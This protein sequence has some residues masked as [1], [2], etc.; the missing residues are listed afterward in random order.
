MVSK[1]SDEKWKFIACYSNN[2]QYR[3]HVKILIIKA[4]PILSQISHSKGLSPIGAFVYNCEKDIYK[5]SLRTHLKDQVDVGYICS[6][7]GG[8]GHK[9]AAAFACDSIFF[10]NI[11]ESNLEL[12]TILQY[13]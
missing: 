7:F 10:N 8:G 13:Y 3:N 12:R 4:C 9:S 11:I 2:K 5:M 1:T 6:L